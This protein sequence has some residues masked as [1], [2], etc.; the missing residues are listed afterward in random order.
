MSWLRAVYDA[1]HDHGAVVETGR[2]RESL[3]P[4]WIEEALEATGTA[5]IRRRRLPAEQIIWLVLGMALFADQSIKEVL[6]RLG[7]LPEGAT[8]VAPSS[9]TEARYRLGAEPLAWLFRKVAAAWGEK[10][11]SPG[12]QGLRLYAVDGTSLRILDTEENVAEFGKPGGRNGAGDSGYAQVR[13]V[14]LMDLSNRLLR[15]AC[16]GSIRTG[17]NTFATQLFDSVPVGS[18]TLLDRGLSSFKNL[19][20]IQGGENRYFLARVS[21]TV[22]FRDIE[23]LPDGSVRALFKPSEKNL[24]AEVAQRPALEVRVIAY[25]NEGGQPSRLITSLLDHEAH[26]ARNL[27]KLYHERWEIELGF[28]ELKTTMLE[29]KECLRSKK[30]EGVKQEIW[31]QLLVYNLVRREMQLAAEAVQL[32]PN[33]ISF[34]S[35]LL[36]CRDLWMWAVATAPG[37]LPARLRHLREDISRFVLPPRRSQRRYPRHVKI[38]M[39]NYKRNRGRS[40]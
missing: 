31:A 12:Y 14:A 15:D 29:R 8:G 7:L 24:P 17:E 27:V 26:P 28:G 36:A 5:S 32:P 6:A 39:S 19:S 37:A 9:M 18:L 35:S 16:F 3:D 2:F 40:A 30:P 22:T 4:R 21:S 13:V 11:E 25:Q 38:K 33:R 23:T 34:K 1:V 20:Q 10:Q